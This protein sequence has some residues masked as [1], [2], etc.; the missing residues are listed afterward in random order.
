MP[1]ILIH[2]STCSAAPTDATLLV[3]HGEHHPESARRSI[4]GEID[5]IL[6]VEELSWAGEVRCEVRKAHQCALIRNVPPE[7]VDGHFVACRAPAQVDIHESV[8]TRLVQNH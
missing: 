8:D 7:Q 3:P 5:V 4:P 6:R 1:S 2:A